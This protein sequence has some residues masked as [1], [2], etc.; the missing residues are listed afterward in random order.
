MDLDLH[1]LDLIRP[2]SYE[3]EG[4]F[5]LGK[6]LSNFFMSILSSLV[7]RLKGTTKAEFKQ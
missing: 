7:Q 6:I 5:L 4:N 3:K 1:V 2:H